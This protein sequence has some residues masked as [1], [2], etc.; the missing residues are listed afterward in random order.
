MPLL[1]LGVPRAHQLDTALRLWRHP[2][3][4]RAE[5][6]EFQGR[7]LRRLVRHADRNLPYYRDRFQRVGF[8]ARAVRSVADLDGLPP[9][10]KLELLEE[11]PERLMPAGARRDRL[12]PDRSSGSSG[13][14]LHVWREPFAVHL[15][16]LFRQRARL[17]M[18][19]RP[20]ERIA[21]VINDRYWRLSRSRL[22]RLRQALGVFRETR[23][24]ALEPTEEILAQIEAARPDALAGYASILHELAL[25]VR[26]RGT[27]ARPRLILPGAERL[28][29][30]MRETI[31]GAFG[32]PVLERYVAMEFNILGWQCPESPRL[33]LCDDNVVVELLDEHGAPVAEGEVGEVVAT[34]L[35]C[36]VMPFIRYRLGDLAV[37]GPAP[38]PCGAPFAT[39]ERIQGRTTEY[40]R[41]RDGG[42]VHL[43]HLLD[44]MFD[45]AS[46]AAIHSFVT[47]QETEERVVFRYVTARPLRDDELQRMRYGGA[48]ALGPGVEIVL[49]EVAHLPYS[50]AGKMINAVNLVDSPYL[51]PTR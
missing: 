19:I 51:E 14:R 33:H 12:V 34:G 23:I 9:L 44:A 45:S 38:C 22:T 27:T 5:L 29:D 25:R 6:L 17:L 8:D 4:S 2:R 43:W 41:R 36:D 3:L 26:E 21:V 40:F 47:I 24:E 20:S 10:S 42:G 35:H 49:E 28:T 37:R 50:D 39:L 32:A 46:H 30:G 7:R 16:H 13:L 18:G 11:P 31:E 48:E 1:D 15:M